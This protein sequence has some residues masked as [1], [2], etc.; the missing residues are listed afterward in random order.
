MRTLLFAWL[1]AA[2]LASAVLSACVAPQAQ[3]PTRKK[4]LTAQEIA[5]KSA[6]T[7]KEV[8]SIHFVLEVENGTMV[9]A[10]GITVDKVEGD[11]V[12]P[13]R[14]HL[15]TTANVAGFTVEIELI[16]AEGKQY[17]LNPLT[18]RWEPLQVAFPASNLFEP[19]RGVAEIMKNVK[20]LTK[21]PNETIDGVDSYHLKG[22]IDSTVIAAIVGGAASGS[23]VEL[24]AWVGV[25]DFFIRQMKL[26]GAV[27]QGDRAEAIRTLRLSRFNEPVTIEPPV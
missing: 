14:M 7:M 5:D 20:N 18:R 11:A 24:E 25:N 17:L 22:T 3:E 1:V 16:G 23:P 13:D 10:P 26:G 21:L 6:E 8:K 9:V 19:E 12:R 15:N 4:E 27:L 2:I